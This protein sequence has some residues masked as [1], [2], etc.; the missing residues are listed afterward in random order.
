MLVL[1]VLGLLHEG[2]Y[3]TNLC[4]HLGTRSSKTIP[5]LDRP[6]GVLF[7]VSDSGGGSFR[8]GGVRAMLSDPVDV[9]ASHF[10]TKGSYGTPSVSPWA[11][12]F[13]HGYL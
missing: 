13:F 3:Q 5:P 1:P 8:N 2:R 10:H 11:F 12:S 4:F 6:T 9:S 7:Y